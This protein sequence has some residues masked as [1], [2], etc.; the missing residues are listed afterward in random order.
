MWAFFKLKHIAG[1]GEKV[2][3]QNR[4]KPGKAAHVGGILALELSFQGQ[5]N[6]YLLSQGKGGY[7]DLGALSLLP[8]T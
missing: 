8:L 7:D 4:E 5:I 1:G 6:K 2:P 3:S